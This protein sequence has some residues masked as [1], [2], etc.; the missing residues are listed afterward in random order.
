MFP[1]LLVFLTEIGQEP[2]MKQD[3]LPSPLKSSLTQPLLPVKPFMSRR[4]A[5]KYYRLRWYYGTA[6]P[7][8][9]SLR[10]VSFPSITVAGVEGWTL[11]W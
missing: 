3:L 9:S 4:M 2:V 1:G 8:N 6:K 7:L 11:S 10:P 5:K